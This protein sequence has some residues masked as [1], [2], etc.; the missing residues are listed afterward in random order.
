[1]NDV[2]GECA[3]ASVKGDEDVI[4]SLPSLKLGANREELLEEVQ[5]D[6]TLKSCSKLA[7]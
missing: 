1:L 7:D 6:S 5:L 3:Q 2:E 4:V